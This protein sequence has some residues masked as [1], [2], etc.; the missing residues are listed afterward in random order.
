MLE[1]IFGEKNN[2]DTTLKQLN[3][4]LSRL[5]VVKD[6]CNNAINNGNS[7]SKDQCVTK[8]IELYDDLI[9]LSLDY[10]E[11]LIAQNDPQL[12]LDELENLRKIIQSTE[13]FFESSVYDQVKTQNFLNMEWYNAVFLF[14]L[15]KFRRCLK[16]CD[17]ILEV[18]DSRNGIWVLKGQTLVELGN[19][20]DALETFET[21]IGIEWHNADAWVGKG[22]ILMALENYPDALEAFDT[23]IE[24]DE[25]NADAYIGKFSALA[26]R[27]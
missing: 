2:N 3:K 19:N 9:S 18:D 8:I 10:M 22:Q 15:G 7:E 20:D 14:E 11:L 27:R 12:G 16:S 13:T 5:T 23:A 24:I 17:T 1:K 4:I 21:A 25:R 6:D 26:R